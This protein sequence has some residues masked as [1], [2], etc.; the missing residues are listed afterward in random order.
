M[1][2]TS[3]A[4]PGGVGGIQIECGL[5]EHSL[6]DSICISGVG[7]HHI[8]FCKPGGNAN[9]YKITAIASPKAGPPTVVSDGC[10][11]RKSTRLNSSH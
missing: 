8:T 2:I 4:V 1:E 10:T 5:P 7:P 3:G 9:T 6:G 11:D